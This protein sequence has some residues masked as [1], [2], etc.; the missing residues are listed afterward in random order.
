MS[1]SSKSLLSVYL[2]HQVLDECRQNTKHVT[3]QI[4]VPEIDNIGV[5]VTIHT[6]IIKYY[7]YLFQMDTAEI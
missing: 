1:H 3:V 2:T 5:Y 7:V 4:F 6:V